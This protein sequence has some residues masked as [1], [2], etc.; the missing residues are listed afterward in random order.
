MEKTTIYNQAGLDQLTK[1]NIEAGKIAFKSNDG[2]VTTVRLAFGD[3][4]TV[5]NFGKFYSIEELAD[6]LKSGEYGSLV[7]I[8]EKQQPK[9]HSSCGSNLTEAVQS[10]IANGQMA[11]RVDNKFGLVTK[12]G[13]FFSVYFSDIKFKFKLYGWRRLVSFL[14]DRLKECFSQCNRYEFFYLDCDHAAEIQEDSIPSIYADCGRAIIDAS[15]PINKE[16][17]SYGIND[18]LIFFTES[19][20]TVLIRRHSVK[21]E[22]QPVDEIAFEL[23]GMLNASVCNCG[24]KN[25][26]FTYTI[27]K[28]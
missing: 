5:G 1:E 7:L 9:F 23:D 28:Q 4:F 25:G 14:R 26:K 8:D 20:K 22:D 13:E 2:N 15:I 19:D 16:M 6:L 21:V 17:I 3:S 24:K 27:S 10:L 18:L 12:E 11:F